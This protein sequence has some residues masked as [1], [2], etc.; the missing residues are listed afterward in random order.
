MVR[1]GH[2]W[3]ASRIST[4][5]RG[6]LIC[7][8][9]LTCTADSR[10][11]IPLNT[12]GFE[13]PYAAG[14]LGSHY[15]TGTGGQQGWL[16]TDFNQLLGTPAGVVQTATFQSGLQAFHVNGP[17][18]FD[19]PNFGGQTFWYQNYPVAANAF[20][21]VNSGTPI[22]QMNFDQRVNSTGITVSDMPFVGVY[23]E[24]YTASGQQQA[25]GAIVLNLN[26]GATAFTLGGN[27]LHTANNIYTHNAWHSL[28]VEFNFFNQT[29]R[30][31]L[32]GT[33]LTFGG[34]GISDIPFRNAGGPTNRVAEFGFQA[35]F[36]QFAGLTS[37]SAY[38]DNYTVVAT[39]VPEPSSL[40]LGMAALA[41]FGVL[42]RRRR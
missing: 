17:R 7:A 4:F 12:N 22:V 2:R 3:L 32:D 6:V 41:G 20:N 11:Q 23:M 33:L 25:I 24:G 15:Q 26:R 18:L 16:T 10:A 8:A 40:V 21:P 30:A 13:S 28:Q 36:N 37:N 38:F 19:D 29:Y 9:V 35:S 1:A 27:A 42:R 31:F 5:A 14:N 34:G 39:S